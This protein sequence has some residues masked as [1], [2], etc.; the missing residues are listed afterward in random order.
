MPALP[1]VI[2]GRLGKTGDVDCYAFD[3]AAGQTLNAIL[4]AQVIASPADGALRLID[5]R[6]VDSGCFEGVMIFTS[7]PN[8]VAPY[9]ICP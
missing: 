4:D 8:Y 5:A 3:L 2:T 6:G 9:R 7:N 1:A